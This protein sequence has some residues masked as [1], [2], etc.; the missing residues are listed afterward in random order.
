MSRIS[1]ISEG[2]RDKR[3]GRINFILINRI[4]PRKTFMIDIEDLPM[5]VGEYGHVRDPE[6]S[7]PCEIQR[8]VWSGAS[9]DR[10]SLNGSTWA[11][12]VSRNGKDD[13]LSSWVLRDPAGTELLK[14]DFEYRE[15]A[16]VKQP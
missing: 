16:D 12:W 13:K 11:S 4:H 9:L 7:E 8:V 5:W 10:Q 1:T 6:D 15:E 3:L 14:I 2:Y